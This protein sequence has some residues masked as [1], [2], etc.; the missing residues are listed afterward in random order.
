MYEKQSVAIIVATTTF[1]LCL[2]QQTIS[3]SPL[4]T[5]PLHHYQIVTSKSP[6][7]MSSDNVSGS[8]FNPVPD[9]DDNDNN[10]EG[11]GE[12]SASSSE[13]TP[14]VN[15]DPFDLS[16]VELMRKRNQKPIASNPSTVG[17]VPTSKKG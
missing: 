15:I 14:D 8:F 1:L 17:G 4:S 10:D 5:L 9:K 12:N 3:F 6:I 2:V 13:A 16:V 7:N 11:E